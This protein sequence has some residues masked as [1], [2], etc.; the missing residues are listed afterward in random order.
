MGIL[1][2]NQPAKSRPFKTYLSIQQE[3][4]HATQLPIMQSKSKS[5]EHT[6]SENFLNYFTGWCHVAG[7]R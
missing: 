2:G 1:V 4:R 3:H 5:F 7:Y 6:L